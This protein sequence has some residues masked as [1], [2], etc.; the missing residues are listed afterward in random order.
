MPHDR[1]YIDAPL[2]QKCDLEGDEFQHL[3][4]VMRK[5]EG[6]EIELINGRHKLAL[7]RI[8]AIEKRSAH[9]TILHCKEQKPLLPPLTLVQAMPKLSNLELI[10]QKGTELGV[11][12]FWIF[13][14]THSEKKELSET[15]KKRLDHIVISAMKQCGR[16]DRPELKWGF[17]DPL[18]GHVYVGTLG[19]EKTPHLTEVAQHP[20]TLIIGP[21]KGLTEEEIKKYEAAGQ[22]VSL[23][24][25]TL[26]A[27]TA[28]IAGLAI[29]GNQS[30]EKS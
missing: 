11:S 20:A 30:L 27:E 16:L 24:P 8:E 25:Y 9:L 4:R 22:G 15:Q 1:F 28:A 5:K 21:E 29:L 18:P 2:D 17:P 19:G 13:Q 10:L 3:T 6:D 14:S 26:R 7:A 12:T 23:G